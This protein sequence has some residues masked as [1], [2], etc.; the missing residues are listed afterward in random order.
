M[1]LIVLGSINGGPA[2]GPL[3]FGAEKNTPIL[4]GEVVVRY[5]DYTYIIIPKRVH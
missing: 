2:L 5:V 4:S 3:I 1:L